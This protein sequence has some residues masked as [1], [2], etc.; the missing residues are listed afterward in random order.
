M[1]DAAAVDVL[2]DHALA[3]IVQPDLAALI[4]SRRIAPRMEMRSWDYGAADQ[5]YPCWIVLEHRTSNTAIAYCELGFGPKN[6]WGL[7]FL[8][9]PCLSMG[10]NS[11]WYDEMEGAVRELW[12]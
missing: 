7:L 2:L 5:E 3:R 9:G 1:L 4:R 10:M 6:P 12:A 11:G 8:N